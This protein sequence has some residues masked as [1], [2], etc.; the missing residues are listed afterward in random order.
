MSPAYGQLALRFLTSFRGLNRISALFVVCLMAA[1]GD[2]GPGLEFSG[3]EE[4]R[5]AIEKMYGEYQ[6]DFPSAREISVEEFVELRERE[7]IL[8]VDV[9]EPE[10]RAVSGIPGAVSKEEFEGLKKKGTHPLV[11]VYCTIGYRS[12]RYV[13]GLND[14]GIDAYNLKGSILSWVHAGHPVVD[15]EGN[16]TDRVHVYGARWNLL[17][18]KYEAIW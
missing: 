9:R 3:D 15:P 10:E 5:A 6:F 12:G 2:E 7:D 16:E 18:Q 8:L 4:K 17:P 11:V 1:C 14:E 13:E